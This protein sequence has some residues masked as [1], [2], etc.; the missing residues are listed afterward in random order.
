MTGQD[1]FNEHLEIVKIFGEKMTQVAKQFEQMMIDKGYTS[2]EEAELSIRSGKLTDEE[3]DIYYEFGMISNDFKT[4]RNKLLDFVFF[5][6]ILKVEID[7]SSLKDVK[8]LLEFSKEYIPYKTSFILDPEKKLKI[9][10]I[11]TYDKIKE[12]FVRELLKK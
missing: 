6:K 9:E 12:H 7:V 11:E 4:Q 2:G 10:N 3:M 8:G 1:Y 5:C